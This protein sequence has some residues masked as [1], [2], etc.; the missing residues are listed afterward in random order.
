MPV[1]IHQ[2]QEAVCRAILCDQTLGRSHIRLKLSCHA[3]TAG[4]TTD[5]EPVDGSVGIT[6]VTGI[7]AVV[8]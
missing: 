1:T 4:Q 3:C 2:A 6:G 7:T 8:R 5:T